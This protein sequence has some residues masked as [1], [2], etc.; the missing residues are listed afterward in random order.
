[1]ARLTKR[2]RAAIRS[3]LASFIADEHDDEIFDGFEMEDA[4]S[5]L[6][7]VQEP[8]RTSADGVA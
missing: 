8:E 5:A 2:E 7:K 6:G 4:E 1:M 3:A